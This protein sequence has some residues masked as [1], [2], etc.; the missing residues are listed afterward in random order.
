MLT[1]CDLGAHLPAFDPDNFRYARLFCFF[2]HTIVESN[3]QYQEM[4][5]NTERNSL[6][7]QSP[8]ETVVASTPPAD[9]ES[10]PMNRDILLKSQQC[11]E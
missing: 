11:K 5:Q 6:I 10:K 9:P 8:S 3:Y 4:N 2:D 7:A 1:R